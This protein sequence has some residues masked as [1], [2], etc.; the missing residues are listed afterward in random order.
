M[1]QYSHAWQAAIALVLY[2]TP[3]IELAKTGRMKQKAANNKNGYIFQ[4]DILILKLRRYV[5][6]VKPLF[7]KT[8]ILSTYICMG[9]CV[10]THHN[11]IHIPAGTCSA[12]R[13]P[14]NPP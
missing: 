10:R 8:S 1:K 9:Y 14:G 13:I 11:L 7:V 3:Q 2:L 6:F 4:W 5:G 12:P